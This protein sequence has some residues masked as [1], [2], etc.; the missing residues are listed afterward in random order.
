MEVEKIS[1]S[2]LNMIIRCPQQ[3]YYRYVMKLKEPPGGALVQGRAYH[4]MTERNY[5]Q[6]I[7]SHQDIKTSD[8]KDIFANEYEVATG[9]EE[10]AWKDN[11]ERGKLKDE[12]V[13]YAELF[14]KEIA[15]GVTPARVEDRAEV[16][17]SYITKKGE[18]EN[19]ILVAVFDLVDTEIRIIDQKLKAKSPN[20]NELDRDV[21]MGIYSMFYRVKYREP[22]KCLVWDT[23]VKNKQP[24]YKRVISVRGD[25][26]VQW[27]RQKLIAPAIDMIA[28][29]IFPANPNG[30]HCDP[31]YCGYYERCR[32]GVKK[33]LI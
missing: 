25:N 27:L 31:K 14:G 9:S 7:A 28:H 26:E 4:K 29:E 11:A 17:I 2:Q 16:E 12:G 30:W 3:Y 23:I 22:E 13:T 8:L 32:K 21:Q 24:V 10:I 18:K 33:F 15:P 20:Q 6:K 19:V 1:S 5:A